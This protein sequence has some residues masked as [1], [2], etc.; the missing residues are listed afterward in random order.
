[1]QN[2]LL[3]VS[4]FTQV[5]VSGKC[6]LHRERSQNDRFVDPNQIFHHGSLCSLLRNSSAET[7]KEAKAAETSFVKDPLALLLTLD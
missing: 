5:P 6:R 7:E 1:M 2:Q 4:S 3:K